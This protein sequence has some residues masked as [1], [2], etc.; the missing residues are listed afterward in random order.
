MA[1]HYFNILFTG[2]ALGAALLMRWFL[3]PQSREYAA[4]TYVGFHQYMLRPIDRYLLTLILLSIVCALGSLY[5]HHVWENLAPKLTMEGLLFSLAGLGIFLGVIYRIDE[6]FAR[7]QAEDP[8]A[9]WR[10]RRATWQRF[11][12]VHTVLLFLSFSFY[13]LGALVN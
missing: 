3:N 12:T 8:V 2:L 7:W 10:D 11:H 13:L 9:Q 5:H 6:E 4:Q 1:L